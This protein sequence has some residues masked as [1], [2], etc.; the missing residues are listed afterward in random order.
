MFTGWLI[1]SVTSFIGYKISYTQTI[2][3]IMVFR[4]S[5]SNILNDFRRLFQSKTWNC[6]LYGDFYGGKMCT[7]T[8]R[9]SSIRIHCFSNDHSRVF[10]FYEK[11]AHTFPSN[12][13][14]L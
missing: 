1:S 5:K 10:K 12:T 3:A 7:G 2:L 14:N 6:V 13:L 4:D 8:Q 9:K 11:L